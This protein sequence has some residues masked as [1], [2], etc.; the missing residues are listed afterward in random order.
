MLG[1][2]WHRPRQAKTIPPSLM[3]IRKAGKCRVLRPQRS[4]NGLPDIPLPSQMLGTGMH[5]LWQSLVIPTFLSRYT[6]EACGPPPYSA[7]PNA[8]LSGTVL[9][10]KLL[11]CAPIHQLCAVSITFPFLSCFL[12]F[13]STTAFLC[14]FS[15][16]DGVYGDHCLGYH[17]TTVFAYP[18]DRYQRCHHPIHLRPSVDCKAAACLSFEH[19]T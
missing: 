12:L 7:L 18:F 16:S 8:V 10:Q 5:I 2:C 15:Q 4:R 3:A 1:G 19:P 9:H 13:K 14:L 6:M 17:A 11:H